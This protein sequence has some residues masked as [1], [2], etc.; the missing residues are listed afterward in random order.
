[1]ERDQKKVSLGRRWGE[2]RA[3]KRV[4][5]GFA[6]AAV[7]L[8]LIVGFNWGGW[9]TGGTAQAMANDAVVQRLA[10]I[11]VAQFDQDPGN[12]QKLSELK[13]KRSYQRD[14]YVIEQGWA[15]LPG[16]QKPDSKVADACAKLLMRIDQ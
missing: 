3:T 10:P 15:T 7:V 8:T 6:V 16:D 1:M 14:D 13:A 5:F 2:A 12:Q 4:V 11:C 9:V